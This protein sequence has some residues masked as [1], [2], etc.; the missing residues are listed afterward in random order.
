MTNKFDAWWANYEDIR[1]DDA[2]VFEDSDSALYG[3]SMKRNDKEQIPLI[4]RPESPRVFR[5]LVSLSQAASADS[6]IWR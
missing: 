6:S 3:C 5:R 4:P 1:G 2:W